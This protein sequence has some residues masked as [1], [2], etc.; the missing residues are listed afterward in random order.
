MILTR[1]AVLEFF[2]HYR[3]RPDLEQ[4]ACFV[5]GGPKKKKKGVL[6]KITKSQC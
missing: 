3:V 2:V 5:I 4:Q 1:E 6:C